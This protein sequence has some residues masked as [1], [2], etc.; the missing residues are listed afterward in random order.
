MT[1][2]RCSP[3]KPIPKR[4]TASDK[5]ELLPRTV[6]RRI[7]RRPGTG[8][9][10][11]RS[12]SAEHPLGSPSGTPEKHTRMSKNLRSLRNLSRRL[13]KPAKGNG[14]LQKACR[15]ALWAHGGQCSTSTIIDWCYARQLL[16]GGE[17]RRNDFNRAV[18]RALESIGAKRVWLA[19]TIGR[20]WI[21]S[22]PPHDTLA[23]D[24]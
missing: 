14:R 13:P 18:R 17:K 2:Q 12:P 16:I 9:R 7:G 4:E 23:D 21:W 6:R 8:Q 5:G 20:P 24:K 19:A 22:A 10:N 3:P 1:S 15:W 11:G